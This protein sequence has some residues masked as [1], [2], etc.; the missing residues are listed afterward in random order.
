M[1]RR[2]M[3]AG[4]A[5]LLAV[6][7]A[8]VPDAVADQISIEQ[9]SRLDAEIAGVPAELRT[10]FDELYRNLGAARYPCQLEFEGCERQRRISRARVSWPESSSL[11]R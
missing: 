11:D 3:I 7:L 2:L 9:R 1:T 5:V 4:V 10:S 8:L 6:Q